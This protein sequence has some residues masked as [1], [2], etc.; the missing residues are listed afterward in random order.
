MVNDNNAPS[1][2]ITVKQEV[3]EIDSDSEDNEDYY[4]PDLYHFAKKK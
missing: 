4:D 1:E 2:D 3:I